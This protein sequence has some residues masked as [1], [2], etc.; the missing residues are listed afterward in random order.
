VSSFRGFSQRAVAFY[1]ELTADNTR[2]YWTAHKAIYEAEVRDPMRALLA[3]LEAEFGP[4]KIFRPHRDTRFSKDKTP[5]KTGQAALIGDGAGVGYYLQ[6]DARGL[7]VGGGFRAHAP[8]QVTR[9]RSAVADESTGSAV[10]DIVAELRAAGFDIEGEPVK[11]TPRGY[12]ADHPRIEL[13]RCRSLMAVKAF[14]APEWLP[15]PRTRDEVRDT[16][17]LITPLNGCV[18]ANVGSA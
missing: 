17:R 8:E 13:L 2:E 3:D 7:S 4:A 6:I 12:A 9:Y 5:Y 11:T 1:A 15:T 14:G 10:G 16:W 18:A